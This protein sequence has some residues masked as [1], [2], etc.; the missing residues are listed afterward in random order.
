V[1]KQ[2]RLQLIAHCGTVG[3]AAGASVRRQC[4]SIG[5]E[6]VGTRL[7]ASARKSTWVRGLHGCVKR[8]ELP[9]PGGFLNIHLSRVSRIDLN[10]CKMRSN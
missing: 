8:I 4:A 9:L 3:V 10:Q 6:K 7:R 5:R 2:R 1:R